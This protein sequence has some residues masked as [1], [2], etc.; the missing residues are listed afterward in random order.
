MMAEAP[1][2]ELRGKDVSPQDRIL[3]ATN[4]LI[5]TIRLRELMTHIRELGGKGVLTLKR[6][7]GEKGGGVRVGSGQLVCVGIGDWVLL[8]V[9]CCLT[10]P[11][12][13]SPKLLSRAVSVGSGSAGGKGVSGD[14]RRLWALSG[15][16]SFT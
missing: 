11:S 10:L 3:V 2:L 6:R 7:N 13:S 12:F 1:A 9:E 15:R 16:G 8:S 14:P 5:D 4:F